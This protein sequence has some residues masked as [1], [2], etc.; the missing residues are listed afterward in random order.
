MMTQYDLPYDIGDL[1]WVADI[2]FRCRG[3][4][5]QNTGIKG[6]NEIV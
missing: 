1:L 5:F 2:F 3:L 4:H 6:V